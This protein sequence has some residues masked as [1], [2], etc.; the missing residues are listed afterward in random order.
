MLVGQLPKEGFVLKYNK[1]N[2]QH[3]IVKISGKLTSSKVSVS[4]TVIVNYGNPIHFKDSSAM[5]N[6]DLLYLEPDGLTVLRNGGKV[7]DIEPID[8]RRVLLGLKLDKTFIA[9][10]TEEA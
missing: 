9:Y 7:S 3:L 4:G 5:K 1:N 8:G 6:G 2:P 10:A